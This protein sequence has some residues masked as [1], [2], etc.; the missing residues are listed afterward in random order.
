MWWLYLDDPSYYVFP[1]NWEGIQLERGNY[2]SITFSYQSFK[3]LKSPFATN[4]MD[5]RLETNEY[6]SRTDCL[7][8]CKLKNNIEKCGVISREVEVLKEEPTLSSLSILKITNA[9]R[10]WN[11]I[12]I[13]QKSVLL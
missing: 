2:Y 1:S 5:Y 13:V 6:I 8:K 7:R 12:T 9:F 11:R 3:L 10:I 4:C